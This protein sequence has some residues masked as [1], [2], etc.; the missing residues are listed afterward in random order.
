MD[1]NSKKVDTELLIKNTARDLFF[2]EGK[3]GATTQEIADAAQVNRTL[4]NYYFRSRDNL[5]S[6]I[7]QEAV[8][9]EEIFTEEI[10]FS[11]LPFKEKIENY[12]DRSFQRAREFPYLESYIVSRLNEGQLYTKKEDWERVIERFKTEFEEEIKKGNIKKMKP[13]QFIINIASLISFPFAARPLLQSTLRISTEE[14]ENLINQRKEVIMK[15]L[16]K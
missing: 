13:I 6:S 5:F 11:D 7:F 4:I 14:F 10:L 9:Q 12:I 16:F 15:V 8:E 1:E 2:K 3:F